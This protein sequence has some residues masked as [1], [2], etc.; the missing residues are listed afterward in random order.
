MAGRLQTLFE[1]YSRRAFAEEKGQKE[2]RFTFAVSE[3]DKNLSTGF[4]SKEGH[5]WQAAAELAGTSELCILMDR[6]FS[7]DPG[8][9]ETHWHRDDEAVGMP[10]EDDTLRT[11]HA[12]IPLATMDKQMGTLRYMEGTQRRQFSWWEN[13]LASIWG[14]E[15]MWWLTAAMAQDDNLKLGDVAWHDGWVLHSAGENTA[16]RVRDGY[17]VSFA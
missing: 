6:G 3:L 1:D 2:V 15:L 14:W 17:A 13:A 7:K 5:L 10:A 11:V 4:L 16:G 8:D 9:R 12:W